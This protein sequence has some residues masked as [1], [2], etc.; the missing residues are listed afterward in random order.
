MLRNASAVAR[1]QSV[2]VTTC[3]PGQ[4]IVM[5]YD[6]IFRFCGEALTAMR[7]RDR[8]RAGE[9]INRA[10]AV[11]EQ[12][13]VDLKPDV[14]P[15]LCES[16]APLYAFCMRH[17]IE[18]NLHQDEQR[19]ADVLRVLGPLRDA[20]REAARRVDTG[21]DPAVATAAGDARR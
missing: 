13:L 2:Q 7:A 6:G 18:A 8:A 15:E 16:L 11:L 3:S 9:R 1:Y 19:I 10:H 17:L 5:F 20:W 4:L 12:L 14:A 21:A